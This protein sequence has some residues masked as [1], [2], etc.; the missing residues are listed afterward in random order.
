M[1]YIFWTDPTNRETD[2]TLPT[3]PSGVTDDPAGLD[4][5][6]KAEWVSGRRF[7]RST[8][9]WGDYTDWVLFE[10]AGEDGEDGTD[11]R[12]N[13]TVYVRTADKDTSPADPTDPTNRVADETLPTAP[14]GVTDDPAGL[15]D[16]HKAEWASGRRFNRTTKLWGDYTD[17]VLFEV[18]G[19]DGEDGTDGDGEEKVFAALPADTTS[20]TTGQAPLN[21]WPFDAPVDG[22]TTVLRGGIT[23]YDGTPDD[24]NEVR[25]LLAEYRRSYHGGTPAVGAVRVAFDAPPADGEFAATDWVAQTIYRPVG[26]RGAEATPAP[27]SYTVF[28]ASPNEPS[29]PAAYTSTA[30][31]ALPYVP[32][33]WYPT[34][35]LATTAA[36]GRVWT[37]LAS[38]SYVALSSGG[39]QTNISFAIP[40][41]SEQAA[42]T[43]T[44]DSDRYYRASLAA[45][46]QPADRSSLPD[47]IGA[48]NRGELPTLTA[49][50]KYWETTPTET[51]SS[52]GSVFAVARYYAR[53]SS[54]PGK[55]ATF[56]ATTPSNTLVAGSTTW[57]YGTEPPGTGRIWE[58]AFTTEMVST[59]G[60]VN[61]PALFRYSFASKTPT[62][63]T[64]STTTTAYTFST[65]VEWTAGT[66]G[67]DGT[68]GVPGRGGVSQRFAVN[69][70]KASPDANSEVRLHDGTNAIVSLTDANAASV[71]RIEI[72][73][74]AGGTAAANVRR[75]AAYLEI[76]LGDLVTIR[77]TDA[78]ADYLVTAMSSAST[79]GEVRT[80]TLTVAY[81]EHVIGTSTV[82]PVVFGL[83]RAASGTDGTDGEDGTDGR[84][85]ETV[86][87]RT[88][89]KD[90]SPADPTD[91]TNRVADETL[92]TAPSGVTDDPAGLDDTHKAEWASSRRFDRST[93]M[94]GDY[95]DWV[96]FEVAGEDGEDGAAGTDGRYNETVYVRTADKDTSPADPTDP[97]NRVADETLPTAPSGVTADPAGLDDTHKAEWASGRR[98]NRTTK[99]WG[100]YTDWVLFEVA[101]EDGE[102]GAAGTDGR[103]T[104]TV[105]AR[106]ADKDTSPADPTDPTK[107][108]A[109]ETLPTAP[110]GVT[111][112]PAGLDD[113]HKAE[114]AS[115]RR[116][117]RTTKLWGDYTDWVLFEV[118]GED[119][120]DGRY[121]ETV[122][123]RTADKD[124]SPADP[125]DPTNRVADETLPTAPSGVTDDPAGLDDTH[126]AEW[127]SSRR[128][129]RSTKMWGDYTDW[130]L[131]EVAGE[132]GE[133]GAAGT[134]GR[135]TETVYVRTAD[136]D[137]S[138]ADPTDPTNRETDE[139][140]PTAPS[141]VTDD[142]AGLDDTHKAEWASGRRF[143]RTTKLWGD[144]TDWV[145]FEVAGEDGAA[146]TDGRYTETVY[147]RTA[148]KDTS[149]AD[150]TD[151]TN[152]VADE[153]LPTAPSG[154]TADPA[155]LD[156]T[157]KAEWA[158]GRRFNRTTKLWGD[159]TDWVL[160]EVAGEDGEDGAAG[161]DGRYTE[162]VY[163]RTADK[164]TSPADPTDP[165]NRV[166]DETL[167]TAPS[168]VTADPA[169]LDDTHKAEWASGRR[170]NRTTKLWGDYTDW[171]LFEVAG[172]DGEDGAAGT[173]GRYT[174]TVYARTADKDTSPADPTDPTN[175]V[176]DETLPTAPS[177]VTAD[178]AGLDD[179][180]KAEWASGRRFNRTTKLWG[181]YTDWV[182][183][184]VAGEDGEDGA[185]G[186]DGRYTETVYA[187]TADKDTSPAD[188]T[189]PT[190]RVADETLPTAPSGVTADPAGLDDTHKAEWASGRRFN[191]TTKL[192]GDYTD[193]VLFEVAGEDG[194]DGAA[195]TDGRYTETVYAR[196]A[197][198]DT[199]PADPTDPT[200]RVA[201]ETLPTAPSGVTADPAGLD[202]THKAEWASGRRFN[203]TTKLWG[204]YTDWVLF[205]VAGEDG[206]DGAAGTD[207]R[208]TETVYARTADKDTSP[209]DPTDPTN[210]VADET[211]PTA[212]SGVTAD[213][214][215]LDDTHKA[216]WAS[217]RRF[218]RT[219]KLWGDYTDW[220]LFEVAGEDGEDG[221]AGT[222]GRYTETVYARTADKDTSPADPTDP[223][224]RVADETLPTAPSGVTADPAGLDDT[225]KA[226]WASGRRF[227]RTTKLWGDYTDWVLFEVAGEDGTDGRY[228]ETVYARTADKDTSPA[229]PTDPT[230]RVADETLP[231]APS[232]VTDDPQGLTDSLKAEW[233]SVRRFNRTTKMWGDY[234]SWVLSAVAAEEVQALGIPTSVGHANGTTTWIAVTDADSYNAIYE[235]QRADGTWLRESE[236]RV[237]GTSFT[238]ELELSARYRVSVSA[239][240]TGRLDSA[241]SAP[242]EF[243]S[244]TVP[245]QVTGVMTAILPFSGGDDIC[246]EWLAILNAT[247][248]EVEQ[249][250]PGGTV[251]TTTVFATTHTFRNSADG[252][253]S[254]RVRAFDGFLPGAFSAAS[255]QVVAAASLPPAAGAPTVA[256][257]A[258]SEGAVDVSWSAVMAGFPVVYA[259]LHVFPDGLS[260]RLDAGTALTYRVQNVL[261]PGVHNFRV[262]TAGGA[263]P[264]QFVAGPFKTYVVG[265]IGMVVDFRVDVDDRT[266]TISWL[267]S[268]DF[269]RLRVVNTQTGID[270]IV[271]FTAA[272]QL[273][274]LNVPHGLYEAYVTPIRV[275]GGPT[276]EQVSGTV[277]DALPFTVGAALVPPTGLA[278]REDNVTLND[279][280]LR[281]GSVAVATGFNVRHTR[282]D[283]SV[284]IANGV[285]HTLRRYYYTGLAAGTHMFEV[286]TVSDNLVGE[287][288]AAFSQVISIGTLM[289]PVAASGHTLVVDDG[290]ASA[291]WTRAPDSGPDRVHDYRH[292]LVTGR[293]SG[294]N[295][296]PV[297]FATIRNNVVGGFILHNGS[298]LSSTTTT[299]GSRHRVTQ[300]PQ[301]L[302]TRGMLTPRN[303]AGAG[304][305]V[306][307]EA[308]N[309]ISGAEVPG[310]PVWVATSFL[311]VVFVGSRVDYSKVKV[312]RNASGGRATGVR[313]RIG[314]IQQPESP[315][316]L[317]YSFP[318]SDRF[319]L[320]GIADSFGV[321]LAREVDDTVLSTSDDIWPSRAQRTYFWTTVALYN[322][323][324]EGTA[325]QLPIADF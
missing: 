190:N 69:L 250:L 36:D 95:T 116:F 39:Y 46:T 305:T 313:I 273:T 199:S 257:V 101:G 124:T 319:S 274:Y 186:T 206:E 191:R 127:A 109:D 137:T 218:N 290:T 289:P 287:Y 123:A 306:T 282:P 156:D 197:D 179:T 166:A 304:P 300:V 296:S 38:V 11:G 194:E 7:D 96:L 14:S 22:T 63:F 134:D 163:A 235:W 171:V 15:D 120:T 175:R 24:L 67:T 20:L 317:D 158:S 75:R 210:R 48:W 50:Q 107:R 212:P 57:Y 16:T 142:P 162:T 61:G 105:Y 13:E 316:V 141:G 84:Y 76:E 53:S 161:T 125:T 157:H 259:V 62:R 148:D 168:G 243:L 293:H 271:E 85:T 74:S 23:W 66:T 309:S 288:S 4:D 207:G 183:F 252:T 239:V 29:V 244:G 267:D 51:A 248:Y 103:Y 2:E 217:G 312:W 241:F 224:N 70:T 9:M 5:T 112:D 219:T 188:P 216:E 58:L 230:N 285:S 176:A 106:T 202:D 81:E 87:A 49:T 251:E 254:F 71:T 91:P 322:A 298:A 324:G 117:N 12:Y 78:W 138:P 160:F 323:T 102:D 30:K 277:S 113:T 100:D 97:T 130:V 301:G 126:K 52:T 26:I 115:G 98:F 225:H 167:P 139:T 146:G 68:D 286:A 86:Y 59:G 262:D 44:P 104:E 294:S 272:T 72:G 128:F 233:A 54:T 132:D 214:A 172:E 297:T 320:L 201:D 240:K 221:A 245:A 31:V 151:P 189:D 229:D 149:P 193:W 281:W 196:T 308:S 203:R 311:G 92:P 192:W 90:T 152:R 133:D 83:S 3:A 155:G 177:G 184:E 292:V 270:H 37:S 129:D 260:E 279:G 42:A 17:W 265:G 256:A 261:Q 278:W 21:S 154:V 325:V 200:N 180:H 1:N 211:L 303:A 88:A 246:V 232:G 187:R 93:K 89:D 56:T 299:R 60:F 79:N 80:V 99:L 122:Y 143:N 34:E 33:P 110:S 35:A 153:T 140:L 32:V 6:H 307:R 145:L 165:T 280:D 209:A 315:V 164:D 276:G 136:K 169:G 47:T 242:V 65:P 18:A 118:A 195:G 238:P 198:K 310:P 43:G 27:T 41:S 318:A 111:A 40:V 144:Y 114:W 64:Q 182:L 295:F 321:L 284:A 253:H 178:P 266:I 208:Y 204:D 213:P 10:V 314:T 45:P 131:F 185:A 25:P 220:V 223:T 263:F 159:Y 174:E 283:G 135:Y 94:W 258:D 173:D 150:P 255:E 249:T 275:I 231:T 234:A 55:P 264:N 28:R 82:N 302:T 147:A 237:T 8:K 77:D 73:I 215:G 226:E 121:D 228:D 269:Y 247:T 236:E 227:N 268:E 205:E 119:G 108:V 222:D 170:F 19:E 181:D 291:M